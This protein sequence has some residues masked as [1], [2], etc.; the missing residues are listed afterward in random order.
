MELIG[1]MSLIRNTTNNHTAPNSTEPVSAEPSLFLFGAQISIAASSFCLN[2]ALLIFHMIKPAFI[3]DF[4]IYLLFLYMANVVY[5]VGAQ[6]LLFWSEI[7]GYDIGQLGFKVCIFFNYIQRVASIIPLMCH[8]LVAV[9]RFWALQ[10]PL[11]YRDRHNKKVA[12][13]ICL[14]MA[15]YVHIICLPPFFTYAA[16]RYTNGRCR[17]SLIPQV[18]QWARVDTFLNR[19]A[20]LFL[21]IFIYVHLIIKRYWRQTKIASVPDSGQRPL[22]R[23]TRSGGAADPSRRLTVVETSLVHRNV[24]RPFL[25]LTLTTVGVI[26]CWLPLDVI[27]FCQWFLGMP[28]PLAV[29]RTFHTLYTLQI[30]FDPLM[31]IISLRLRKRHW[32]LACSIEMQ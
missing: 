5:L 18:V 17:D 2:S 22:R 25:V 15:A 11:C 1:Q 7:S 27:Y 20:P 32:T 8:F 29:S 31:W 16:Y 13:A 12:T 30:L 24:V 23:G 3:T 9:N 4:T 21:I 19:F 14:G 28:I 10:Y 6:P 26:V